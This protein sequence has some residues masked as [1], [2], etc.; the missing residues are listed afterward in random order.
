MGGGGRSVRQQEVRTMLTTTVQMFGVN[1]V[2]NVIHKQHFHWKQK[3]SHERGPNWSRLRDL[4]KKRE[5]RR[6]VALS[7][8]LSVLLDFPC[9]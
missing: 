9:R 4:R 1:Y 7:S 3:R 8:W 5:G 2:C 6:S